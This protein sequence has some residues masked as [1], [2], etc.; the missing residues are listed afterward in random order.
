MSK[1]KEARDLVTFLEAQRQPWDEEAK[2]LT[3]YLMPNKGRW[4]QG[5]DSMPYRGKRPGGVILDSK[6]RRAHGICTAGLQGGLTPAWAR[7][8]S[9]QL[10]NREYMEWKPASVWLNDVENRI[11]WAFH[12]SNFYQ[13]KHQDYKE[14]SGFGSSNI[15]VESHPK[16][17]LHF[18]PQ[19]FGEYA[20]GADQFGDVDTNVRRFHMTAKNLAEKFGE[21][22]LSD[23]TRKVLDKTPYEFVEVVQLIQPRTDRKPGRI[24][25]MN[26]PWASIWYE[27]CAK[28]SDPLL[29]EGG[30]DSFP[31]MASRWD[32]TA[33]ELYGDGPGIAI[34]PDIKMLQ[35]LVRSQLTGIQKSIN[36]PM[37]VP[38]KYKKRVSHIPGGQTQMTGRD[39]DALAPLYQIRPDIASIT[40]KIEDVRQAISEGYF[41]PL[42]QMFSAPSGEGV[43][44]AT[45]V[46]ERHQEKMMILGSVIERQQ[47]ES[48]EPAVQRVYLELLRRGMIPPPPDEIAGMDLKIEFVSP[49]ARAQK[50]AGSQSTLTLL[51]LVGQAAQGDPQVVDKVDWDQVV[52]EYALMTG[53]PA[54]IVRSDREVA[55]IRKARAEKLAQEKA[56]ATALESAKVLPGAA[57]QLSETSVQGQAALDRLMGA[58]Q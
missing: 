22:R 21:D 57:Q 20:W 47:T 1:L 18:R 46:M 35:E 52:D 12:V 7:W 56:E 42:F 45:E 53:A 26:K 2:L 25:Y 50:M 32:V 37:R 5:K 34:L 10:A 44:T 58:V 49:L 40:A 19:T 4:W 15:Y 9:V 29:W 24:D 17:L 51:T 43:I 27:E 38:A 54:R 11:Y 39:P 16:R 3:K 33:S 14:L 36:P 30:Y 8:F 28:D 6:A 55:Q 41:N 13:A 31:V 23:R 48:L